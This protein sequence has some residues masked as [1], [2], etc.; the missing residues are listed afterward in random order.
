MELT[1]EKRAQIIEAYKRGDKTSS[2]LMECG[3]N[4]PQIYSVLRRA[5]VQLRRAKVQLRSSSMEVRRLAK[6][7]PGVLSEKLKLT[8]V[9][10]LIKL[11]SEE[12]E[13]FRQAWV[14]KSKEYG[15][16]PDYDG[17]SEA[18][19]DYVNDGLLDRLDIWIATLGD[20]S[21]AALGLV[22]F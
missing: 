2:I 12:L 20:D 21:N 5:N 10:K 16:E 1:D 4:S 6:A 18:W 14:A 22:A 8:D 9:K 7:E 17:W 13:L 15:N 11:T 3:V 19:I